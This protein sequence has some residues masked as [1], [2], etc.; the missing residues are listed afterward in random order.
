MFP[1]HSCMYCQHDLFSAGG[2]E[3]LE[4]V[5]RSAPTKTFTSAGPHTVMVL[6][7]LFDACRLHQ[8]PSTISRGASALH[9]DSSRLQAREPSLEHQVLV[10]LLTNFSLWARAPP[11]LQFGLATSLLDLVRNTPERCR[12]M[13]SVGAVLT[14]IRDCCPHRI[15]RRSSKVL[16][17]VGS[18]SAGRASGASDGQSA[19]DMPPER[20]DMM[21]SRDWNSMGRGERL[22]MR[23]FL[24]EVVRLLLGAGVS[25]QDGD[26]LV[27]F[28]AGCDDTRLVRTSNDFC[29]HVQI[30]PNLATPV[31]SI[32]VHMPPHRRRRGHPFRSWYAG[33]RAC[34]DAW[35]AH[36]PVG[37]SGWF[38][39]G[40]GE[41]IARLP[42]RRALS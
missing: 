28:V 21:E 32:F 3:I 8:V 22:H 4:L 30:R 9:G 13:V 18:G 17:G 36:A 35:L 42:R 6:E 31:M 2:V 40:V 10:C 34:A 11:Q 25:S 33:V 19:S 14:S 29:W 1:L 41:C 15:A 7:A 24:W 12:P 16:M 20:L 37:A 26:D 5:L 23:I 27:R 38:V 39:P